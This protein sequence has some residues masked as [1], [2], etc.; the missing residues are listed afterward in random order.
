MHGF[1][2]L[3][4]FRRALRASE[5]ARAAN[6]NPFLVYDDGLQFAEGMLLSV[7]LMLP[8]WALVAYAIT[9]LAH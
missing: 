3:P 5:L 6:W 2:K 9:A 8:F 4:A 7:A 1:E